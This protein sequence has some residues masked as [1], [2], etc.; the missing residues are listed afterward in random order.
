MCSSFV[1]KRKIESCQN[2]ELNPINKS[3]NIVGTAMA[4]NYINIQTKM[5]GNLKI[6]SYENELIQCLSNILNNSKDALKELDEENRVIRVF[7]DEEDNVVSIIIH[8]NAGGIPKHLLKKVFEPYFTTKHE[9]QGT[10][11]GLYMCY[12]IINESLNGDIKIVNEEI[13]SN[14]KVYMG[15]KIIIQLPKRLSKN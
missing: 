15:A 8:D 9:S 7:L 4:N 14:N 2:F 3:L 13:K 10:G 11:L 5:K 1:F 6:E 12:K